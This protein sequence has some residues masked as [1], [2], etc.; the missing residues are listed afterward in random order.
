MST[1]RLSTTALPPLG[2]TTVC[3]RF[4]SAS[5]WWV[6]LVP[7]VSGTLVSRFSKSHP[8][9]ASPAFAVRLPLPSYEYA[10]EPSV[11]SLSRE[12]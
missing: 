12:S 1:S 8:Y 10:V 11:V 5:Y 3:T 2:V 6:T 9:V 7:T 4:P